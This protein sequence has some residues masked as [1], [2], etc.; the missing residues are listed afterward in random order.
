MN[1]H[2]VPHSICS[3]NIFLV[4]QWCRDSIVLGAHLQLPYITW[5]KHFNIPL[6]HPISKVEFCVK[7]IDVFGADVIKISTAPVER[8]L[9]SETISNWFHVQVM[10]IVLAIENWDLQMKMCLRWNEEDREELD[11]SRGL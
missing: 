3:N 4:Q 5:N 1:W 10:R 2:G 11:S 9:S 6:A 7:D 8:I